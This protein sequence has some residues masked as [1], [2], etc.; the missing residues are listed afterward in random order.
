MSNSTKL[1]TTIQTVTDT[2]MKETTNIPNTI[3]NSSV[4]NVDSGVLSDI[5]VE[6]VT[7]KNGG[8]YLL[9]SLCKAYLSQIDV[10]RKDFQ[11]QIKQQQGDYLAQVE[12]LREQIKSE[13]GERQKIIDSNNE[14]IIKLSV[15]NGFCKTISAVNIIGSAT[16]LLGT[17]IVGFVTPLGKWW[18]IVIGALITIIGSLLSQIIIW[19]SG[20]FKVKK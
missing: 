18:L 6:A 20:I 12:N 7:G 13:L 16:T 1:T 10:Q 8:S 11:N 3:E 19:V 17:A 2:A 9:F 5:S 4:K 15:E 14:T